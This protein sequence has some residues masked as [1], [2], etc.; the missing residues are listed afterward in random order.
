MFPGDHIE[1]LRDLMVQLTAHSIAIGRSKVILRKLFVA[2]RV[3]FGGLLR[4]VLLPFTFLHLAHL[5]GPQTC[6]RATLALARLDS[7]M[8]LRVFVSRCF[9][10]ACT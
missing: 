7:W 9:A 8:H 1:D 4:H 2:V 6:S 10:R 5:V 3:A